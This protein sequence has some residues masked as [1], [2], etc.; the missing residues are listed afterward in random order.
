MAQFS[1]GDC[2]LDGFIEQMYNQSRL[3]EHYYLIQNNR[4][5]HIGLDHANIWLAQSRDNGIHLELVSFLH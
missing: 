5:Y 3:A 2:S 4:P 1:D